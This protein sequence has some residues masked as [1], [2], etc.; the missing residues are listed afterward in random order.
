[1]GGVGGWVSFWAVG[2]RLE[3]EHEE[4]EEEEEVEELDLAQVAGPCLSFVFGGV[5]G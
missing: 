5:G 3:V 4:E 1:M 2:L